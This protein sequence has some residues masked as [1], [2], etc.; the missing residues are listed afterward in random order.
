MGKEPVIEQ[1]SKQDKLIEVLQKNFP[2]AIQKTEKG[3]LINKEQLQR[4]LN[5][6]ACQVI[7]EGLELRWVG[8]RE[9]YHSAYSLTDKIVQPLKQQSKDFKN[10]GN[11]LIKGDNLDALKLLQNNYFE[12]VKMIYIDPPYNTRN[13]GFIYRD[14]FTQ[15]QEQVLDELGY[16]KE[17]KEYVKNIAS[18]K[19]HSGWLS[20]MYPRLL[21][22]K[23]LLRDNGVIFISI[24]DNEQANLK[25]LCDEVFGEWNF[26][27]N[28]IW[29]TTKGAQGIV[30]ENKIVVNNENILCYGKLKN[31]F[32]FYGLKRDESTGFQN[33]DND[34]KGLWKRQYLQRFGHGFKKRKIINPEN[35]MVFEFET[36]YTQEKMEKWIANKE[37]IFPTSNAK[38]PAKK[39][40]LAEYKN[41]K[42]LTSFLGLFSTK[43]DTEILYSL[44]DGV[45]IFSNPKPLDL[46]KFLVGQATNKNDIILDFFAGSGTTGDT[47][48]RLNAEDGGC[49]KFVLVQLAEPIDKKKNKE[50]YD[51][52][53]NELKKEPTIFEIAAERLR[54]AEAKIEKEQNKKTPDLQ[55]DNSIKIDTGFRIFELVPDTQKQIYSVKEAKQSELGLKVPKD[56][57]HSNEIILYN[58]L[59]GAGF[60]LGKRIDC[61]IENACYLVKTHLLIL[62]DFPFSRENETILEKAEAEYAHIYNHNINDDE[63][64]H[65]L[66]KFI[67][68]EKIRL[69]E[70]L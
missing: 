13:D 65:N 20:F 1:I 34:P 53:Q 23:D 30:R 40:Y 26:V 54:R 33:P 52:V 45:K 42:Q 4:A 61:I 63:F 55:Q 8:K 11:V 21:L 9:A 39:E 32:S 47:V 59:L 28:L 19:T 56:T 25:L 18:A 16:S 46:I 17:N 2:Q 50:A 31:Q 70:P 37:I 36:P 35:N 27:A 66:S 10:T 6:K 5:P 3:F 12:K 48:M 69:K 60:P 68:K 62:Q 41:Q 29:Q 58:M 51:F 67:K 49:R 22:A 43:A 64:I 44:F 57:I 15:T 38:Y 24:D 14:N 7:D